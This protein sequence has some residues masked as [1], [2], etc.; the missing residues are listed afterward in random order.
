[1]MLNTM[2][3]C[4]LMSSTYFVLMK[5]IML[6]PWSPDCNNVNDEA[7]QTISITDCTVNVYSQII[8]MA[9]THSSIIK[10]ILLG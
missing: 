1:M 5:K 2:K 8:T 9:A 6:T 10:V 7:Y 3:H 4:H